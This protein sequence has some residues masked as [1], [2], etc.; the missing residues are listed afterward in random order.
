MDKSLLPI[1]NTNAF[2]ITHISHKIN[3]H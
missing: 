1:K 2:Y 3:F